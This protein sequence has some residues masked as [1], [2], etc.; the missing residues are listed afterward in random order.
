MNQKQI[1]KQGG[2]S[3]LELL[4]AIAIIS[5]LSSIA[6]AAFEGY[7]SKAL[8][9]ST[10]AEIKD[11]ATAF[12]AYASDNG[13]YP[14]DSHLDLPAGMESFIKADF[15]TSPSPLTGT[16]NWE[17]PNSYPYAGIS[18]FQSTATVEQL[19]ALDLLLD[20]GNLA[21]GRFRIGDN[22]RPTYIVN[23]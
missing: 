21:N 12:E 9:A 5:I 16:Y 8:I 7:K 1:S 4:V 20:N 17:G 19:E 14:D 18:L 15:W 23:E 11:L 10:A 3:L 6:I 13:D 2:F 22:G